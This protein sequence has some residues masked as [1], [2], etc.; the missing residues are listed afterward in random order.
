MTTATA[1]IPAK[2]KTAP[3]V[4]FGG[5]RTIAADVWARLGSPKQYI[6][7]FAGSLAVLL[8]A[9]ERASLEVIGDQNFYVANFWRCV[10][11][12][13]EK[14]AVEADY[15]VSHVDLDARHR[16]LTDPT[17]TA[18]LRSRLADPEWPGDARIAG[19]WVWGQCAWIGS[20]WCE[21]EVSDAGMGV[22]S[23]IPHVSN[24]GRGVQSQIPHVG[25]AG[26]GVQSQIPHVGNAGMGVQSKIPHVGNAGKGVIEW[27]RYLSAR[28]AR[29]RIIHG[30]W[31]RTLNHHYGG[32]DTAIFFDPPY[33]AFERLY[34]SG[35]DR[36]VAPAVADWC[37]EHADEARI[38]L[39]GHRGDYDLPGW[40]VLEWSRVN[41]TYGSTKTKD[42]EAIWFS[43]TCIK[44]ATREQGALL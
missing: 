42:E 34:A 11:Y 32:K 8:A 1:T 31:T 30:D 14:C 7:P 35:S 15:P 19:W 41:G 5:K 17:R 9:P 26:M 2:F 27:F 33:V 6:E 29:V 25:N 36:P 39:C 16:W 44:P 22:Q 37:R 4:Y 43:P 23:K 13:P 21:R 10:R 3:F 28:L 18:E 20:G 40:D 12:Q 38:A 24:A